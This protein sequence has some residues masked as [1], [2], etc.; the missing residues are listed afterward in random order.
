LKDADKRRDAVR[1]LRQRHPYSGY[2][3]IVEQDISVP[4]YA[5]GNSDV[6]TR[7]AFISGD[8]VAVLP[9]DPHRDRV[10]LIEQFRF[11]PHVRGDERP[12][13]LEAI[14][15]RIDAGETPEATAHREMAEETGLKATEL[16]PVVGYYTAPGAVAEFMYAFIGLAELPDSA[17]GI[18]G[19]DEEAEDIQ[20]RV[21]GFDAAMEMF[22]AG[23]LD[24][25][26]LVVCLLWLALHR[27]SIRKRA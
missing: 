15:G 23:A 19:L 17:A 7:A 2:F 9:Y 27:E 1:V 10:M 16:L 4:R 6:V 13:K 8:A 14:A 18:G 3:S 11:G 24:T 21:I 25:G 20:S 26:P 22:E 12:W 5:G